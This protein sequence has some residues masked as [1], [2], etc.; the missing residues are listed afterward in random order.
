MTYLDQVA[1]L[2]RREC[3]VSLRESQRRSLESAIERVAPGEGPAGFLR[4][5]GEPLTGPRLIQRLVDEITVQET[6]FLR[7]PRELETI[8]W[9]RLTETRTARIWVAGCA[10]GEEA[11]S[12]VLL[13]AESLGTAEPPVEVLATDVSETALEAAREARYRNKAVTGLSQRLREKYFTEE[14]ALWSPLEV[15][16]RP[17]R[18]ARHNLVRDPAPPLGEGRFDLITCRNVLIYFDQP[19]VDAVIASLERALEPDGVLLLGAADALQG[20]ARRLE[21]ATPSQGPPVR[22]S[23][24]KLEELLAGALTAADD[25]R[26]A[27]AL[28]ATAELLAQNPLDAR[29]YFVQGLV[30]L[31]AGARSEAVVSLRRAVYIDPRFSLASFTLGRAYDEL[32]EPGD[33]RRAYEQ[34][35]RTLD[36]EDDRHDE[37]LRQV[38]LGDIAAACRA[39]IAALAEK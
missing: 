4:L 9:Q 14:D 5:A 17:V 2:V 38:D 22:E 34:T 36:P 23:A 39:R 35:L 10:T 21:Q 33:A 18:F 11:Y 28:R 19:T 1:E 13:A 32:G 16:R 24:R 25:G 20:A 30:Q 37:L 29:A 3:G 26:H 31:A 6:S 7:D 15:L 27:E 12:L 8:D